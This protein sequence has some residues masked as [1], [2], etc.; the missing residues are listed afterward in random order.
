MVKPLRGLI[1]AVTA[2]LLVCGV[3]T[4][5]AATRRD[6]THRAGVASKPYEKKKRKKHARATTTTSSETDT[7]VS[8]NL[9][10]NACSLDLDLQSKLAPNATTTVGTID[11]TGDNGVVSVSLPNPIPIDLKQSGKRVTCSILAG[12]DTNSSESHIVMDIV[13]FPG[14]KGVDAAKSAYATVKSAYQPSN[15]GPPEDVSGLGDE[16]FTAKRDN[17]NSQAFVTRQGEI[18]VRVDASQSSNNVTAALDFDAVKA[19][20][21][22][23]LAKAVAEVP[24]AG[25]SSSGSSTA[26]QGTNPKGNT[27]TGQLTSTG[28]VNATWLLRVADLGVT[29]GCS[30]IPIITDDGKLTGWVNAGTGGQVTLHTTKFSQ[31]LQSDTGG[32]VQLPTGAQLDEPHPAFH[33][34]IDATVKDR[35]TGKNATKLKGSFDYNCAIN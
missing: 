5:H 6:A 3:G 14:T 16:A 4:A 31:D 25:S 23:V 9:S 26:G 24:T 33:V 32:T 29:S 18:L 30:E 27:G 34:T 1:V 15:V 28:A 2:A 22:S 17:G 19:A 11:F 20:T 35:F 7:I 10:V 12:S 21:A 8:S 13:D